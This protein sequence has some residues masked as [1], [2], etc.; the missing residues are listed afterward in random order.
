V[1]MNLDERIECFQKLMEKQLDDMTFLEKRELR[2]LTDLIY[3]RI[4][5]E[6]EV[7]LLT[8]NFK[9]EFLIP[10]SGEENANEHFGINKD[11]ILSE[12]EF[13]LIDILMDLIE[14]DPYVKYKEEEILENRIGSEIPFIINWRLRAFEKIDPTKFERDY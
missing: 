10:L 6:D 2:T 13:E 14:A 8:E 5:D 1:E 9:K 4:T 11:Y 12:K 7:T 3:T